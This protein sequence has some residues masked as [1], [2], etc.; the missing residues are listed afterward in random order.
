NLFVRAE[1]RQ[2]QLNGSLALSA[3]RSTDKWKLNVSV[4]GNVNTQRFE[5]PETPTRAAFTVRNEQRTY[6]ANSL[7]VRSLS[8]HWSAGLKL[9]A[10]HSD[11]LNQSVALRAQPAIEYNVFPWTEQTRRQ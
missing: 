2:R 4:S 1:E 8:S 11:F 7:M 10:G 5:I 6:D 9:G 3:N